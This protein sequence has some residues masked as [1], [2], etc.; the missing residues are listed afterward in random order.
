MHHVYGRRR[1]IGIPYRIRKSARTCRAIADKR[2]PTEFRLYY[3]P[4]KSPIRGY[5]VSNTPVVARPQT[6][7]EGTPSLPARAYSSSPTCSRSNETNRAFLRA[8]NGDAPKIKIRTTRHRLDGGEGVVFVMPFIRL[9][10][11]D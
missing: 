9:E 8:E 4:K 2:R 11:N 3:S 7:H 10:L 6:R 5:S 1:V